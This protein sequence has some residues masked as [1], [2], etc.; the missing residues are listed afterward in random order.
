MAT[1]TS[2]SRTFGVQFF[3]SVALATQVNAVKALHYTP[4]M[5]VESCIITIT[6]EA[7][8]GIHL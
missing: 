1:F 2:I 4:D 8:I 3:P 7:E 5:K 6:H